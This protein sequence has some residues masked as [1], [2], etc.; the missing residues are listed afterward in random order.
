MKDNIDS[1]VNVAIARRKDKFDPIARVSE[2]E[3]PFVITKRW[4][5]KW[6]T[7]KYEF[8]SSH[9]AFDKFNE[10]MEKLQKCI[11]IEIDLKHSNVIK[12]D[13]SPSWS[14]YCDF[15]YVVQVFWRNVKV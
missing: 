14:E 15:V 4:F 6:K 5:K 8:S 13:I 2:N 7:I 12:N 11:N 10:T 9:S 3:P 1:I